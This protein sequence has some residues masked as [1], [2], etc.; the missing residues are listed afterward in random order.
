MSGLMTDQEKQ[1]D[2]HKHQSVYISDY[3]KFADGKAG[4][5]LSVI[6]VM[7][8][9]FMNSMKD[10]WKDGFTK[11]VYQDWPFY[12]FAISLGVMLIGVFYLGWTIWPRYKLDKSLYHSWG[13]I[14]TFSAEEYSVKLGDVFSESEK[15]LDDLSSQNH[16]LATVCK[17][18]YEKL[19]TAYW[20][21]GIGVVLAS[22]TW[23]IT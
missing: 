3:I 14:S 12:A 17:R 2:Y 11:Q 18:K 21:L 23:L 13:G 7:I 5:T 16:S 4:V 6:G 15:F 8:A 9:F 20:Y 22:T 10:L 19:R 1:Y